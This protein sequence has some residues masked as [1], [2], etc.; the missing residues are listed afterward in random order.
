MSLSSFLTLSV[1]VR[2][3]V[4]GIQG[5]TYQKDTSHVQEERHDAVQSQR[6]I[7]NA[8]QVSKV[9]VLELYRG[10]HNEV[11]HGAHGSVIIQR[12]ERVHA[13]NGPARDGFLITWLATRTILRAFQQRL[14]EQQSAALRDGADHCHVNRIS[15]TTEPRN[16]SGH[17]KPS[18]WDSVRAETE[19]RNKKS[20]REE[21]LQC[22]KN[23]AQT[24]RTSPTPARNTPN[25][26]T[27]THASVD[28][29]G[30]ASDAA[31]DSSSVTTGA[32]ALSIWMKGTDRYRYA[33]F[34]HASDT[35]YSRP[36]GRIVRR[37]SRPVMVGPPPPPPPPPPPARGTMRLV[38]RARIC[39]RR[40]AVARWRAVRVMAERLLAGFQGGQLREEVRGVAACGR[41]YLYQLFCP[42]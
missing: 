37:Y 25:A 42:F 35:V 11:E 14:Y 13:R 4:Q 38:W 30:S 41:L 40:E 6:G 26:M 17:A 19:K 36:M 32:S 18:T 16:I 23:P 8:V 28:T 7:A 21:N 1:C 34:A 33:R 31:H 15:M 5:F 29:R 39:V 27:S 24:K 10:R 12:H 2:I 20:K 3:C 9:K 22:T